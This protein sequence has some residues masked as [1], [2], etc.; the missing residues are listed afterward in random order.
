[1]IQ[2]EK[3]L[4]DLLNAS[5]RIQGFITAREVRMLSKSIDLIAYN[6]VDDELIAVEAKLSKW[7]RAFQQAMTYRI[8]ADKAYIA[9]FNDFSHRVNTDLLRK[10]NIGLIIV[11]EDRVYT[12]FEVKKD[13]AW[14]AK[15]REEIISSIRLVN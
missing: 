9:I 5:F 1:M 14:D 12:K 8:C 3:D 4:V 6:P 11:S 10:Y 7:R 2:S 13:R 15:L